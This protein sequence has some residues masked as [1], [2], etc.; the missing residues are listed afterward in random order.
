MFLFLILFCLYV[1]LLIQVLVADHQHDLRKL[2]GEVLHHTQAGGLAMEPDLHQ[3][4]L[5]IVSALEEKER[6][7]HERERERLQEFRDQHAALLKRKREEDNMKMVKKFKDSMASYRKKKQEQ[8][9]ADRTLETNTWK[10]VQ[11][12]Q[13]RLECLRVDH[14]PN[15][16]EKG[17]KQEVW[18]ALLLPDHFNFTVQFKSIY[19]HIVL[20][21]IV[22]NKA[23]FFIS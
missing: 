1:H 6:V 23:S 19:A 20:L 13:K 22:V 3:A 8:L 7:A 4:G 18:I 9:L 17:E 11:A 2:F 10:V 12:A 21:A 5:T 14:L 16:E 15:E